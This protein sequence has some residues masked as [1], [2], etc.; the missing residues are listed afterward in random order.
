MELM[1]MYKKQINERLL[2]TIITHSYDEIFITDGEGVVQEVSPSCFTLYGVSSSEL[3]GRN[4]IDLEKEGILTPSV[5]VLAL[6]EKRTESIVQETRTGRKIIVTAYPLFNDSGDILRVVSFSRDITELVNLKKRNE[7]VA[8]TLHVYKREV[9]KLK[10]VPSLHPESTKME[11]IM[12][13]VSKVADLDVIVLLEGESGVGKNK[14]AQLLHHLSSRNKE[15]FVEVNCG[16]VPES[17]FESELFGYEEGA[18]TGAKKGGKKGS[19]EEAG[20]GTLFLDEIAELS[21]TLQVKLLSVLQSRKIKRVGGNKER[22]ANCRII[23]ATN[24]SLQQLVQEKQFREDLYYRIDVVKITVPPLRD[25]KE[26]IGSLIHEF[27]GEFNVKYGIMKQFSPRM[28]AWLSQRDWPG[29][30][31]ELRN[32]IEK[33]MITSNEELI[34]YYPSASTLKEHVWNEESFSLSEYMESVEGELIKRMFQ[35]YPNSVAL[36]K[37]LGI[38]QSTANRKI[39]KYITF[40]ASQT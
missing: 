30:I 7:Q 28:I 16:A 4:V 19:F 32:Y 11:K 13:I 38:S 20:S 26:E 23:C 15:P 12:D 27:T 18:F 29:N 17:L 34:D 40:P 5:T 24:R 39:Q 1:K 31:R 2:E 36:G 22:A 25:R 3:I 6:K 14:L 37:A 21:L 9:E 8:Q 33:T 35:Q 10:Q